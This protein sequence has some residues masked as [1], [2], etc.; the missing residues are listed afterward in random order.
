MVWRYCN[1]HLIVESDLKLLIH[2]VIENY[3]I[4]QV[5]LRHTYRKGN[6][7]VD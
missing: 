6:N 3:T 2:M 7:N 4:W 1:L 5:Q